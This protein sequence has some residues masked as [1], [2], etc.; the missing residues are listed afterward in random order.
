[1]VEAISLSDEK[2]S[3]EN[4]QPKKIGSIFTQTFSLS[5]LDYEIFGE[6]ISN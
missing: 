1:L 2:K 5:D 6:T 4:F 3:K